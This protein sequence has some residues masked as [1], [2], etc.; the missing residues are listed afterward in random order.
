MTSSNP[1]S[2]DF[3]ISKPEAAA[4]V[5]QSLEDQ[6]AAFYLQEVPVRIVAPVLQEMQVW[7]ASRI[8]DQLSLEQ[9]AA[10]FA[11]LPYQTVAALLRLQ[12][13]ARR[14]E[15]LAVLPAKLARSLSVS[16]IYQENTVGAWMDMSTPG[17]FPE[18]TAAECLAL[19]KKSADSFGT[20]LV[21]INQSH[22]VI[23][24]VGLDKLLASPDEKILG[25]LMDAAQQPLAAEMSIQMAV[26][27]SDWHCYPLLPVRNSSG[28]YLGTVTRSVLRT[29]L[30]K[31]P[32]ADASLGDSLLSHLARA[33]IVTAT[34]M[35]QMAP[36]S[37]ASWLSDTGG[38]YH[39]D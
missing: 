25:Q 18:L 30:E 8:L 16:L 5:L 20:S 2:L 22:Q 11:Q 13:R 32:S 28:V 35:V 26:N 36:D 10:I 38:S 34:G 14:T 12:Q 21:I 27:L 23:G 1:L 6:E 29:A 9:N 17:F 37:H 19:L 7:P 15:L 31:A 24:M 3:L 39:D 33:M 4:Q